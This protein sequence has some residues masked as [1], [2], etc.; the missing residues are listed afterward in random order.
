MALWCA[1][2]DKGGIAAM[3]TFRYI[4]RDTVR[5]LRRHWGVSLLTLLTAAAVFFLVGATSMFAL[6]L[7]NVARQVESDLVVQAFCETEK[8]VNAAAAAI[9]ANPF[10]VGS[11][12]LSPQDAM[13]RLRAKLGSKSEAFTTTGENPLPWTLELQVD[14]AGHIP[15]VVMQLN[16]IKGITDLAYAGT[17]AERLAR[18]SLVATQVS[19]TMVILCVLV[20]ALVLYNTIRIGIYSRRQ[21]ISVMLLVGATRS[22]V[23]SPFVVQGMFL[24]LAGA[25]LAALCLHLGYGR[26]IDNINTLLPFLRLMADV[27]SLW[28][29]DQLLVYAGFTV[30]W[31][32]SLFA[33]SRYVRSAARPL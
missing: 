16:S 1:M 11:R 7:R 18:L 25:S 22:Y 9:K 23:A 12:I 6:T 27:R 32:C 28:F 4:L 8:D 14:R 5:I 13:E 20:S 26:V 24:G 10:I 15:D 31:L 3:G 30:G 2:S 17:L 21:E 19:I 29:L 33:V